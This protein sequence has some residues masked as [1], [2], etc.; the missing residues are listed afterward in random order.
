MIP[1]GPFILMG[2][3]GIGSGMILWLS[4]LKNIPKTL[5]E[6]ADLEGASG[7]QKLIK[8]HLSLE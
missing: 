5:Y 3:F 6:S 7:L 4:Q 1:F 2:M 8:I